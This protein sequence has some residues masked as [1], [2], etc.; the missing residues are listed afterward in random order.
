MANEI[1]SYG[2]GKF[3]TILDAYVY[4]VSLDGGCDDELSGYGWYG[5]MRHGRTIFKDHD[6]LLESLNEAE[7]D[8]LTSAAGV[9]LHEDL[10]G[11]VYV[12]YYDTI[13]ALDA[14]WDAIQADYPQN[15][16]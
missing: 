11:F 3:N 10:Q 12:T 16:D 2:P 14:D 15:A 5:L 9:I 1:R 7:Q 8:Q 6:P 13:E 4:G